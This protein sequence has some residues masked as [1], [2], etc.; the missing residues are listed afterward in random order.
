MWIILALIVIVLLFVFPRVTLPLLAVAIVIGAFIGA[1]H[2][3]ERQRQLDDEAAVVMAV[4]YDP[5][6]CSAG[7]PLRVDISNG[8]GRSIARIEWVFSA[9]RPGY[10]GELTGSWLEEYGYDGPVGA[11]AAL[12]LCFPAPAIDEYAVN[13]D[14][15]RPENLELGIRSRRIVFGQ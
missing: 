2:Y 10:R 3:R 8:S 6:A 12:Q 15:D 5:V 14:A 11:G 1:G 4:R 13:R 9:R 7:Q